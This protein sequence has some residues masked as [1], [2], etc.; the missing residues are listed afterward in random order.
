[1]SNPTK[2]YNHILPK[3]IE[4]HCRY[5]LNQHNMQAIIVDFSIGTVS[6][7]KLSPSEAEIQLNSLNFR[8]PELD[9]TSNQR[10]D[11]RL[12]TWQLG[13]ISAFILSKDARG[14][15]A[16]DRRSWSLKQEIDQDDKDELDINLHGIS[17]H[18][19]NFI[20]ECLQ[21]K[22]STRPRPITLPRNTY[23]KINLESA[24]T[25]GQILI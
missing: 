3:L 8:A 22:F 21:F 19:V 7:D 5:G 17:I 18:G 6:E 12:D 14:L 15:I 16:P 25:F 20:K 13:I 2:F 23:F 1:M 9:K 24:Q 4:N 11:I 10:L